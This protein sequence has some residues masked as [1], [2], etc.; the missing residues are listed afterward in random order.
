MASY[1]AS[2]GLIHGLVWS[3]F[4][5]SVSTYRKPIL[6]FKMEL[7]GN[8]FMFLFHPLYP[9]LFSLLYSSLTLMS[10]LFPSYFTLIFLLFL[11]LPLSLNLGK[12]DG[13]QSEPNGNCMNESK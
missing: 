3:L 7:S 2:Y 9:F 1:M 12:I 6:G 8:A 4:S 10:L 5:S 11:S 13:L